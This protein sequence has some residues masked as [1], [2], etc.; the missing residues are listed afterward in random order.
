M[1][2]TR[3]SWVGLENGQ[4][5]SSVAAVRRGETTRAGRRV[6]TFFPAAHLSTLT[7]AHTYGPKKGRHVVPCGNQDV[8]N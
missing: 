8:G 4:N 1:D 5:Y 3:G 6:E 2:I 7:Q